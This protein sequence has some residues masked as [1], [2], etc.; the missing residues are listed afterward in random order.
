MSPNKK[1]HEDGKQGASY[2]KPPHD[3]D[4]QARFHV[5]NLVDL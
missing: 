1:G 3:R 2:S 4:K 5:V